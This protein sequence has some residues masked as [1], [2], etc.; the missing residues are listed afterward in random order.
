MKKALLLLLTPFILKAKA[1]HN[2]QIDEYLQAESAIR[3][4]N[5]NV[6][7]AKA[8]QVIYQQAFGYSNYDNKDPLT[9]NSM[10]EI[11]S[12]TKP[13]VSLAIFQLKEQGKLRLSDTLRK[14][15][16]ELPYY[17][18]TLY[19]MLTHTSGLP[20][21]QEAF[22]LK[23]EKSKI[24]NNKDAIAFLIQQKLPLSFKPGERCEYSNVGYELLAVIVERVSGQS[25]PEYLQEHIC[26]PLGMRNTRVF[27]RRVLPETI[28]NYAYGY[29]SDSV[30]RY[31][32]PDSLPEFSWVRC[33]D[34]IYGSGNIS[35]TTSDLYLFDRALKNY[36]L[37]S[38]EAQQEMLRPRVLWDSAAGVYWNLASTKIGSNEFGDYLHAGPSGWPGY[39]GDVI[40]YVKD[41]VVIII[42]SNNESAVSGVSG[43]ITYILNDKP[44]VNAYHHKETK[45]D[46]AILERYKGVYNISFVPQPVSISIFSRDGKLFFSIIKDTTELKPESS[47]KFFAANGK[48]IQIEFVPGKGKAVKSY[49]IANSMKKE[50][51]KQR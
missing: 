36:T 3:K 41:D 30:G 23:W 9:N 32:L 8:G 11:A 38:K 37:L 26:K 20:D 4:F 18:V 25:F 15:I 46:T 48:D 27:T 34:G 5:G 7:V 1:Q 51:N 49:F 40:R 24:A 21:Y 31:F 47:T 19:Q 33:A 2:N 16:P 6:L 22:D 12:I 17:S 10:F 39:A 13:F 14:F 43:A 50:M 29:V 44:I 45:I 28:P 35:S 42:L